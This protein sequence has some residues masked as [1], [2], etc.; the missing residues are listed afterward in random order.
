MIQNER[1]LAL[2]MLGIILSMFSVL[3]IQYSIQHE[4][5]KDKPMQM[6]TLDGNVTITHKVQ[7]TPP[8]PSSIVTGMIGAFMK[9]AYALPFAI[10]GFGLFVTPMGLLQTHLFSSPGGFRVLVFWI[11]AMASIPITLYLSKEI[12]LWR[13]VPY[14]YSISAI[15]AGIPI[16]LSENFGH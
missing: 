4:E 11:I 2:V 5:N 8:A 15:I 6:V 10:A 7:Q 13:R 1:I 9:L 16:M 14:I 3:S 12:T